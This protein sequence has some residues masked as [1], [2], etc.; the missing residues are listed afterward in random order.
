M[1][2]EEKHHVEEFIE[3]ENELDLRALIFGTED[4]EE[5][6]VEVPEWKTKVLLK[7]L[8]GIERAEYL[9]MLDGLR[10]QFSQSEEFYK[11]LFFETLRLGCLHPKTK[12]RIFKP[13]DREELLKTRNGGTIETLVMMIQKISNLDGSVRENAKKNLEKI[14]SFTDT[15]RSQ[16]GVVTNT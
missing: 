14:Q 8:S 16:N 9:T 2:E 13:A 1:Q 3:T 10:E 4:R 6:L 11:R 5:F 7:P 15:T 12:K